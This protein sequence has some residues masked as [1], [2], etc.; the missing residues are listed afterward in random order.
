MAFK[1]LFAAVAAAVALIGV[2]GRFSFQKTVSQSSITLSGAITK[3]VACPDGKNTAANA[4]CCSLFAVRDD[5]NKNL[6][7]GGKC[8]DEAHEAFRLTFHDAI[9]FSPAL[10]AKGQFG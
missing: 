7:D 5:L 10:Q 3:R 4:A 6:F 2:Q 8:N 1:H 9:A